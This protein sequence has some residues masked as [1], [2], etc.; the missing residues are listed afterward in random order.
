LAAPDSLF[1]PFSAS[2]PTVALLVHQLAERGAIG[3]DDTVARYWPEFGQRGKDAI[4][5]RQVLRIAVAC[6]SAAARPATRW[7]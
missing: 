5:I 4:T 6:P 1:F 7:R 2:K 3:L